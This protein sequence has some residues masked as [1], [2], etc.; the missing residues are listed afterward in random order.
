VSASG[1]EEE[2]ERREKREEQEAVEDSRLLSLAHTET[3]RG[4]V[5]WKLKVV[6]FVD[7]WPGGFSEQRIQWISPELREMRRA[8]CINLLNIR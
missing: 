3:F 6:E 8:S 5:Y 2:K 7:H 1:A 4:S